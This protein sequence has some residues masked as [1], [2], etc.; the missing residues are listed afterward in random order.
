M[1]SRATRASNCRNPLREVF[2]CVCV[3]RVAPVAYG[4]SQARGLMGTVASGLNQ[5]HSNARSELRL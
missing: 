4:G 1:G 5:S 3:L 2:L